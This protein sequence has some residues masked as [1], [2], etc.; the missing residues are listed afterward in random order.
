MTTPLTIQVLAVRISL[1]NLALS[2]SLQKPEPL[3]LPLKSQHCRSQLSTLEQDL[4]SLLAQTQLDCQLDPQAIALTVHKPAQ[5]DTTHQF[6]KL[7]FTTELLGK[8]LQELAQPPTPKM[9]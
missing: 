4:P 8:T 3:H 2:L 6:K 9:T 1:L 5:Q 7:R